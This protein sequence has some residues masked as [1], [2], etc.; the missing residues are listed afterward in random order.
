MLFSNA[1]VNVKRAAVVTSSYNDKTRDWENAS[2]AAS[3]VAAEIQF[4]G[5]SETTDQRKQV[6]N[7]YRCLLPL[8]TD[9]RTTDRVEWDGTDYEVDGQP[10]PWSSPIVGATDHV[11]I[12]LREVLA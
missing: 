12:T 1:V 2:Y 6:V 7:L 5:T 11:R 8:G 4:Q 3:G 9:V 10:Q